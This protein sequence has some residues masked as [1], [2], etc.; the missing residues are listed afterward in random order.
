MFE[1]LG[2]EN[3]TPQQASVL[4]AVLVGLLFG[5]FGQITRFCFRRSLVGEDRVSAAGVWLTALAFA[6]AGTQASIAAGWITFDDHRFMSAELP[7]LAIA[8]G[9]LMFGAGMILTRGCVSRLTVLAGTGNLR[10]LLVLVVFAVVAHATIKGVFAPFRVALG[11]VTADLGSA[12]SLANWPGGSWFWTAVIVLAA[13]G[14]AARSGNRAGML[15]MAAVIG[16]LVPLAWVGTGFILF[17]EFDPIAMESLSFTAP[18]S[19][20]LFWVIANSAIPAGFGVGL[21]GGVLAGAALASLTFGGFAWQSFETPA[22]TGRYLTGAALMGVGGV[23][24]G[25]CTLGAG[26]S[27]VPTLSVAAIYAIFMI[28][29]GGLAMQ[30]ALKVAPAQRPAHG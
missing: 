28:A 10:A 21:L 13:L 7:Y 24:A 5:V 26:L 8:V 20:A 29:V 4:L 2:F 1:S 14:Y 15:V 3:V 17:D 6:V 23:L 27:G 12:I 19:D 18:S 30:A 16:L 11:A 25:G 22:Q 9:G